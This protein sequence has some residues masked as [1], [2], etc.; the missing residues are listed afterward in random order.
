MKLAYA[1]FALIV[2]ACGSGGSNAETDQLEERI[3][4][5]EQQLANA[6]ATTVAAST[7]AALSPDLEMLAYKYRL[8]D[9]P[10]DDAEP[11]EFISLTVFSD[12]GG[13]E[14]MLSEL[15][16]PP[17]TIRRIELTRALDGTQTAESDSA[18]A[19]WTYHPDDG[20]NIII[21]LKS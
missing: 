17:A 12:L 3:A 15:H 1:A 6:T 4:Q 11:V 2:A 19:S 9:Y 14:G 21:E 5:L 20:L 18:K 7:T 10:G 13:L 8:I 16:F